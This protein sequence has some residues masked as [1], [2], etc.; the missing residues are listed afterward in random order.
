MGK[1][2]HEIW[3]IVTLSLLVSSSAVVIS[4]ALGMPLGACLG[5]GTMR[6]RSIL[7]AIVFAGMAMPPVVVGLLLY[8]LLSRSG[9]LGEWQWL[10]TTKAMILAQVIL[11]VPFVIGITMT[12][13]E[14]LP[15][16]LRFQLRSL[17]ATPSQLRWT[18]L[19][20]SRHGMMLAMITALGRSLSEVGAVLMAG[21]NI[22]GHTRVLTT[23]ILLETNRGRF[24]V[25]LSLAAILMT[26]ALLMN[27]VLVRLQNRYPR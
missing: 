1:L 21:G 19:I 10:F 7:K 27:L 18:L 14:T 24:A 2:I 26:L 20:E 17:G 8:L 3:P 4:C 23:A 22:E 25:A 13:V 6:G 5:L 15:E 16:D 11:N 12:A 9:V